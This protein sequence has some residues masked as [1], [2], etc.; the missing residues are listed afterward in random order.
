[1]RWREA[2]QSALYAEN[3]FFRRA[4][5]AEHFRTNAHVAAFV[6]AVARLADDIGAQT[7]VD[8]GS[9]GGELLTALQPLVREDVE[10][11]A[12][13]VAPRP[14]GLDPRIA[15]HPTIPDEFHGLLI[16]NEWLDNIACDVVEVDDDGVVR[17]LLVDPASGTESLGDPYDSD[18]LRQWWPLAEP[19]QRAE[20]GDVRDAAWVE[21]VSHVRGA[22]VAIDYGHR[23]AS[24]PPLGSL[25]SYADGRETP[26]VPD[27]ARDVTAHVAVDSVTQ[28]VGAQL[29][30]Q[31]DAL[32]RLGLV[33]DRPPLDLARRDPQAY[34][35]A[36]SR[37]GE[38]GELLAREGLGDFWWIIS[39][40]QGHGTLI[41]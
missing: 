30:R 13:E 27:G 33:G 4:R 37:A 41:S 31:R 20:V 11:V 36:L 34:V 25:R 38:A 10:L 32:T 6:G 40:T 5:P 3:G 17:E 28:A 22:A 15:W 2:W 26:V 35:R 14:P 23:R 24:R 8:L 21:A 29:M 19:G 7:V 18:W 39:D 12:V 1:M 16:A 9:G